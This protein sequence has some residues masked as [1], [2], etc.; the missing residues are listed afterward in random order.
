[1]TTTE[2]PKGYGPYNCYVC[3]R[4]LN[5]ASVLFNDTLAVIRVFSGLPG[6]GQSL[7]GGLKSG[8]NLNAASG[9]GAGTT[10]SPMNW[11]TAFASPSTIGQTGDNAFC[12]TQSGVIRVDP[13]G[14]GGQTTTAACEA[15]EALREASPNGR[16]YYPQGDGAGTEALREHMTRLERVKSVL[17]EITELH[18][19]VTEA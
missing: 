15:L 3:R 14:A 6:Q 8:Y 10:A 19:K 4:E 12:I 18:E 7:A 5:A 2:R 13:S 11:Y 9:G 1:M 17:T 16:D